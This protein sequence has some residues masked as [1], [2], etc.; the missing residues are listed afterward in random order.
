MRRSLR[1]LASFLTLLLGSQVAPATALPT[2]EVPGVLG[3]SDAVATDAYLFLTSD[4]ADG[5]TVIDEAGTIVGTLDTQGAPDLLVDGDDLWAVE[6]GSAEAHRYDTSGGWPFDRDVFDVS[7]VTRPEMVAMTGGNLWIV[8]EDDT[9]QP[10]TLRLDPAT[11][12]V[13][14]AA[15]PIDGSVLATHPAH[16]DVIWAGERNAEMI[17]RI[18]VSSLTPTVQGSVNDGFDVDWIPFSPNGASILV[19]RRFGV[20]VRN[21]NTLA[22]RDVEFR[23]VGAFP[24][25][26]S[27]S[28][29]GETVVIVSP[30]VDSIVGG[31]L[32]VYD[33]DTGARRFRYRLPLEGP[34][35]AH[36]TT[37]SA[38][39]DTLYV[40]QEDI[41]SGPMSLT[42]LPGALELAQLEVTA[43]ETARSGATVQVGVRLRSAAGAT[44]RVV[45][46]YAEPAGSPR[47]LIAERDVGDDGRFTVSHVV[48]RNTTFVAE[49]DGDDTYLPLFVEDQV[50]VPA[51]VTGNLQGFY[52]TAGRY[53]LYRAGDE[54]VYV[55]RVK[56]NHQ[57]DPLVF[58]LGR[59][60][61]G[62]WRIVGRTTL[63][64]NAQSRA[65]VQ[66]GGLTT[67][68]NYRIRARFRGD[69]ENLADAGPWAYLRLT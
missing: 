40:L 54:P 57:G 55:G 42:V 48:S 46:V 61:N 21:A 7:P 53:K 29:D 68:V 41:V 66:I 69:A 11:E 39:G 35:D 26:A 56:P 67:G 33:A 1:I 52:G 49:W 28:P 38:D 22:L 59:Y 60:T 58:E 43:P 23:G 15:A 8:G 36:G 16:P 64:L 30:R 9:F 51:V 65:A 25:T 20:A 24:D 5:I 17:E 10:F 63:Q 4:I 37:F 50:G 44:N 32:W 3:I 12:D 62:R 47:Q 27:Y 13:D 2:F 19:Q 14:E 34:V 18:D 31:D 45:R 6:D